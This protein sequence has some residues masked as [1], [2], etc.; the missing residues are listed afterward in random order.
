MPAA[1]CCHTRKEELGRLS[2]AGEK[3]SKRGREGVGGKAWGW[4]RRRR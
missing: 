3:D 4:R 1:E 2:A